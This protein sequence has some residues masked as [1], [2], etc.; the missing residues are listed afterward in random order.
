MPSLI[1]RFASTCC[2]NGNWLDL[3]SVIRSSSLTRNSMFGHVLAMGQKDMLDPAV[4]GTLNVLKAA[5]KAR[6]VK[7]VVLTSSTASVAYR[8]DIATKEVVDETCWSD[9]EFCKKEKVG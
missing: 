1:H 7:R 3:V 5:S 2:K 9:P 4:K 8:S 6:S